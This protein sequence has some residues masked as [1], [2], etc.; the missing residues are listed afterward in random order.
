MARTVDPE[1]AMY[2]E[3]LGLTSAQARKVSTSQLSRWAQMDE[4]AR[5]L[6]MTTHPRRNP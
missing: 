5:R 1:R 4:S 3:L 6:V 2:I